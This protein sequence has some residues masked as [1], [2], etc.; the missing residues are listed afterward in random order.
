MF[1]SLVTL[2]AFEVLSYH[3][4][5]VST[6]LGGAA[7]E[8]PQVWPEWASYATSWCSDTG[9]EKSSG[10]VVSKESHRGWKGPAPICWPG[11]LQQAVPPPCP[12]RV[13]SPSLLHLSLP[14]Y[15][16]KL[17]F[18]ESQGAGLARQRPRSWW[19]G[20]Q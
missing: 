18:L 2:P 6:K 14:C 4:L 16:Q 9:R 1:I 8:E 5:L 19:E 10:I 3:M 17:L 13:G 12:L 7:L 11:S 15:L 20:E